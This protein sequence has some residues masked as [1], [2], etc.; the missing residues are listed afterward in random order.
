M[1]RLVPIVFFAAC[2][3]PIP[4]DADP[5]APRDTTD[6]ASDTVS[7]PTEPIV[8]SFSAD[9]VFLTIGDPV[10]GIPTADWQDPLDGWTY[11]FSITDPARPS[12]MCQHTEPEV[13]TK[14]A[15]WKIPTGAGCMAANPPAHTPQPGP[16]EDT[17]VDTNDTDTAPSGFPDTHAG[18]PGRNPTP[19]GYGEWI[20]GQLGGCGTWSIAMCDRILGRTD[21]TSQVTEAEWTAI[22]DE[23]HLDPVDGSSSRYDRAAY[24]ERRGYC[25]AEK[26][27]DGTEDDYAELT[28][29]VNSGT[30]DVKAMFYKRTAEGTYTNGHVEVVTG[31][32]QGG[33]LTNA[34]G[35]VGVVTG[36]SE[37]N[38][39]HS[40]DGVWM[41]DTSNPGNK[42]W[43]PGS[44]E[45]DVQ[46]V[47]PCTAFESLGR[48]ILAG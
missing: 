26:R 17:T 14:H 34:W 42:V 24:Y 13:D 32:T 28:E 37:G 6:S 16:D 5:A 41:G 33:F 4:E 22:S 48:L 18:L 47:C 29:K 31:A 27:F 11:A 2:Q 1:F 43:P 39:S 36:G 25:V 23:I 15:E 7:P 10:A 38:F 12:Y 8:P 45:V 46:Y 30:C 44:T 20:G 21:P 9:I 3:P 19:P 40:G 35:H